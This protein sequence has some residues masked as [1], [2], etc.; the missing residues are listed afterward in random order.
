M[1][2]RVFRRRIRALKDGEAVNAGVA[3]RPDA[4]LQS[5]LNYLLDLVDD[6]RGGQGATRHRATLDAQVLPGQPVY[7]NVGMQQFEPALATVAADTLTGGLV[8]AASTDVV[9]IVLFKE[10]STLGDVLLA[11]Y[12]Q[13]DLAQAIQDDAPVLPGR[14]Y[15]STR[16]PGRLTQQRPAVSVA[17]LI[18]DGAGGVY[19]QPTLRNFLEDH[20]HYEFRLHARP[21]GGAT[22]VVVTVPDGL[23]PGWLPADHASFAGKAPVGAAYGYNLPADVPL[24][25][26]WP[27]IPISSAN[28]FW[29]KGQGH[30]GGTVVPRGT[31]GLVEINHDGIWW[32]S[33]VAGDI[34][35]P[36]GFVPPETVIPPNTSAGP[37]NPRLEDMQII[38]TFTRML[39]ATSKSVVTSLQPLANS[40]IFFRN[41]DGAAA[42]TGDLLAGI[43]LSFIESP[44]LVRGGIAFKSLA[45]SVFQRGWIAE[46]IRQGLNCQ[47]QSTHSEVRGTPDDPYTLHQGEV[48][49]DVLLNQ[50]E[51]TVAPQIER[52]GDAQQ[53]Y[54]L[55]VPYVG[56]GADRQSGLR[57]V[58]EVPTEGITTAPQFHV[59][60][61]ILAR[62]NGALPALTM[63]YRRLPRPG[64]DATVSLPSA[65]APLIFPSLGATVTADSYVEIESDPIG[66]AAGDTILVYLLR[67]RSD[68]YA[69]EVGVLRTEGVITGPPA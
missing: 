43:D 56:F 35:W 39:F 10:N 2:S 32:M 17:V 64:P 20:V 31:N 42:T 34:P 53:R 51:M 27:P 25:R 7:W 61:R 67:A 9:G 50:G 22:G 1:A 15:L 33:N 37:E 23:V 57:Y 60:V 38:L 47:L 54:H 69:G 3:G 4:D 18:A 11:G 62:A 58:F 16:T 12:G 68:G 21:A 63:T 46:G 13:V 59:R 65:D 29:D 19:V 6:I 66:C 5:N 28:I 52:L 55:D 49:I 26:V 8:L 24:Q 41:C 44:D 30:V 45:G 48:R 14:Y 40:P 36:A